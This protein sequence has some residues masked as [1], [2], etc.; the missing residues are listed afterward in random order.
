[1]MWIMYVWL[2]ERKSENKEYICQLL[3][4]EP[5]EG[6]LEWT[7]NNHDGEL[8]KNFLVWRKE[9]VPVYDMEY[10][11]T[12]RK[13]P[14]Y[15]RVA[16][17]TCLCCGSQFATE[18]TGSTLEFWISDDGEWWNVDPMSQIPTEDE[19]RYDGGYTVNVNDGSEMTCP[20]CW[21]ILTTIQAKNLRGGRIKQLLVTSI[22]VIEQYA[23]VV[24]WLV[25]REITENSDRY[26]VSPRDAYVLDE[27]GT[28][29]RYTHRTGGGS[30]QWE[31]QTEA[32]RMTSTKRDSM[33]M[34]YHDWGSGMY[35]NKKGG[36][37]WPKVPELDGTT[38][39]KT[40]LQAFANRDGTYS[41]A[42]LKL[43][44]KYRRLENLVNTG[45][46]KLVN[47]LAI[48]SFGGYEMLHELNKVVDITK[49]KPHEM[50]GMSKGDFKQIRRN[51]K[52][53]G[54]EEQSMY[55]VFGKMGLGT[56]TEFLGYLQTF[57]TE[58]LRAVQEMNR[59]YGDINLD[60]LSRY[61]QKQN[62]KADEVRILLDTRNAAKALAPDRPLTYEE[63]WPRN[64][65]AA[66]DRLTRQRVLQ[67]SPE[68]AEKYQQ[69]FK[70]V[71]EKYKELQWNDGE[72]CV[73]LPKGYADLVQ[74]GNV[75]RHCVGG[76]SESH[77]QGSHTIFFIRH[78]RRPE[79]CYYT[80][81]INMQDGPFRNQLHGYGNERHGLHK[82]HKHKIPKKVLDFC[83]RWEREVLQPWW[84]DKQNKQKEGKTA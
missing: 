2:M 26:T 19:D 10:L 50:L 9:R 59:R 76:Y 45:W 40:G 38:A 61:M 13:K 83:D 14:S 48:R 73:I 60:K 12:G 75:L 18:Y 34:Q 3:P 5:R 25:R 37:F 8:G 21:E 11:M 39:E 52:Q 28:I 49:T 32:W 64:L 58:G 71:M 42:Y 57:K 22:E 54:F 51:G 31:K 78:Y 82:E 16:A 36:I 33:D 72:L 29:H 44:K 15:E 7:K 79:R 69:G 47:N 1:M 67:I 43:W 20:M 68:I 84:R 74:E 53:W 56:A 62:M 24:Y 81:D 46:T 65:Q 4:E 63:L 35:N 23:A 77:I 27:R 55:Q 80:L 30:F 70:N 17:C 6:L 41:V 66:H